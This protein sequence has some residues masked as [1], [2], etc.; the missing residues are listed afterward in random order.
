MTGDAQDRAERA[1][2]KL[3]PADSEWLNETPPGT[4]ICAE[5]LF[6]RGQIALQ[7]DGSAVVE[8]VGNGRFSMYPFEPVIGQWKSIE[9]GRTS[10]QGVNC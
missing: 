3:I 8:R 10:S 6:G 7:H 2:G 4:A 5:F 9:K 1:L